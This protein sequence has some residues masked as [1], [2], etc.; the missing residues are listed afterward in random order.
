[1]VRRAASAGA[2]WIG[3]VFFDR[4]PRAVTPEA[5]ETLLLSVG[6]AIPVA[7]LVDPDDALVNRITALG[8]HVLQLHGGESPERVAEIKARTGAEIWKA[9]GV[10]GK[11]D[12]PGLTDFAAADRFLIDARPPQDASRP[13]GHGEA[14]DWSILEGWQ[15]PR[16]WLLAGGLTQENVAEAIART[17]A[18]AVDV[19][20]G[21]ERAPGLKDW[22]KVRAFL[23]AAHRR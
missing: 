17:G 23:Q 22:A 19:S 8:I 3:F 7:L 16:P 2:D 13:G 10:S 9:V 18:D 14:F 21:V 12:L 1:M 20:S 5:A 6:D 11:A 4:S 15:A